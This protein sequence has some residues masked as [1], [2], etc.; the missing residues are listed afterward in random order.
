MTTSAQTKVKIFS[1]L[2]ILSLAHDD[3]DTEM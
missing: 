2:N 3:G 1:E